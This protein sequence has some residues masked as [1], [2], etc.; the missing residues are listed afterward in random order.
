MKKAKHEPTTKRLT[1]LLLKLQDFQFDLKYMQGAKMYVSDTLSRLYTKENHKITD[2]IPLNFL[3]YTEDDCT[4]ETYKHCAESLY[5]HNNSFNK[6]ATNNRKILK[7]TNGLQDKTAK[8][9]VK[10]P[11]N[12]TQE[13]DKTVS[14]S[15]AL[16]TNTTI[17]TK[18][19]ASS[20]NTMNINPFDFNT[21]TDLTM[22]NILD[23][24]NIDSS[25]LLMTYRPP[26]IE[27][28][29][30]VKPLITPDKLV[31]LMCK[32]IPQQS[33]ANKHDLL[34]KHNH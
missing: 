15:M 9:V 22:D 18:H 29:S 17:N 13:T 20:N 21:C 3:Q 5:R 19:P 16:I 25:K 32:H 23:T 7:G 12:T 31:S 6:L 4:T 1:V 28:Y 14:N 11:I 26:D 27:L 2:I 24:S 34:Y 10:Q 33:E 8:Q 30:N